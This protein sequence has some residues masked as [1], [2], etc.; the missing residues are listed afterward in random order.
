MTLPMPAGID[1]ASIHDQLCRIVRE[2]GAI[3]LSDYRPNQPTRATV[4]WKE[5]GS[6]VTSADLAVD[7]FLNEVLPKLAP[8]PV[9][10]EERPESWNPATRSAFVIDP[11]DGTRDFADGGHA[12]CIVIGV[13]IDGRPAVGAVHVPATGT[14]FSAFRSGGAFRNGSRLVAPSS[15][16]SPLAIT[17]PRSAVDTFLH[18][19][20]LPFRHA[21]GIPALAHRVLAP[22]DGRAD[23][24]LARA[25]GHDWDIVASD[26]ILREAG[27]RLL[28]L[29]GQ[30]PE[31][32]L[33]GGEQPPL[34]AGSETLLIEI[35]Q[36][37][38]GPLSHL[39]NPA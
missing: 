31:Y 24:A 4:D 34:V 26:C 17:G 15:A 20:G 30:T 28:T 5:G 23:L 13:L 1:L 21:A 19:T 33:A 14:T 22:L 39:T 18:K 2:A 36:R 32:R 27:A 37:Q 11:I 3:A 9:H 12:W 38:S 10:S 35:G 29:S 6:P 8:L 7:R 25:G 16:S